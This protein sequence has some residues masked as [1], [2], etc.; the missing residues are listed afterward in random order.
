ME[1]LFVLLS[2]NIQREPS[3]D[4]WPLQGFFKVSQILAEF[5]IMILFHG[6]KNIKFLKNFG[7][8]FHQL[9]IAY[10]TV[11]SS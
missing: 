1:T 7:G 6:V 10:N 11:C 5:S 4:N 8:K 2:L 3:K 9:L